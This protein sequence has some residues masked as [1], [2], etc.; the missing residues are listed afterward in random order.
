M[1]AR[2]KTQEK[3]RTSP[4][5]HRKKYYLSEYR[6]TIGRRFHRKSAMHASTNKIERIT[7][8]NNKHMHA[9]HGRWLFYCMILTQ[10]TTRQTN[11]STVLHV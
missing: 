5:G 8:I 1:V 4:N 10:L 7:R 2:C 6:S 9:M 11:Y 3:M